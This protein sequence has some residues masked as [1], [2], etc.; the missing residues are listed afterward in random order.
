M[1]RPP[2]SIPTAAT[3]TGT[4]AL[5]LVLT[6]AADPDGAA[7]ERAI[8]AMGDVTVGERRGQWLPIA[9]ETDDP[10]AMH[11]RFEGLA[12]VT[13]VD[14]AFVELGEEHPSSRRGRNAAAIEST[15]RETS[16]SRES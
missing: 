3:G 10:P 5:G 8:T 16:T 1:Q 2:D 14:V 12:G 11:R 6:L 15:A 13:Y 7:A 9:C 4:V